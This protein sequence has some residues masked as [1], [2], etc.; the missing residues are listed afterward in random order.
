MGNLGSKNDVQPEIYAYH[1][2]LLLC[3]FVYTVCHNVYIFVEHHC[4]IQLNVAIHMRVYAG[5]SPTC[6][7]HREELIS[8]LSCS[9][10][11]VK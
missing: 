6:A 7:D 11:D 3:N 8:V 10:N 1:Y 5:S 4:Q 2:Q 9:L